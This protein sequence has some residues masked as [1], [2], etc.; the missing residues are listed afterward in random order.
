MTRG[1]S[2]VL[3]TGVSSMRIRDPAA[4]GHVEGKSEVRLDTI[5][6]AAQM[7]GVSRSKLYELVGEGPLPTGRI[8]RCGGWRSRT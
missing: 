8:G 5:P 6:G 1:T 3:I 7:L 2:A 4:Y